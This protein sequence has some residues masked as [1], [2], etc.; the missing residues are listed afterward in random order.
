MKKTKEKK[1]PDKKKFRNIVMI[2]LISVFA[3]ALII[4]KMIYRI[5]EGL[6]E[7]DA[8][9]EDLDVSGFSEKTFTGSYSS[10]HMYANVE[11][12]VVN[13]QYTD[14]ILTGYSGINPAR[15]QRVIDS[16]IRNQTLLPD[17]GDIGEQFTDIIVQKAIYYAI[18]YSYSVDS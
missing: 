7:Q 16:I 15:A 10:G 8:I 6:V 14:I 9:V 5:N 17:E 3:S 18:R 11:V 2:L 1:S 13:G 12:T 4:P